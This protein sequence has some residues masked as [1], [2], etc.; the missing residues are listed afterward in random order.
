MSLIDWQDLPGPRA[1]P[2]LGHVMQIRPHRAHL[3]VEA[4]ARV[5][6]PVFKLRFGGQKVLVVTDHDVIHEALKQRPHGFRKP[7][8]LAQII[9]EA[10]IAPG[11]FAAEGE[12][13]QAQRQMVMA[14]FS[15][16]HVR[17]Y[18]PS[19]MAVAT[20]LAA[21]WR[22][23]CE[24]DEEIDLQADLMRYT[25]DV[26]SGLA[27]GK[28]SHTLAS[29]D[30]AMQAHLDVV[31]PALAR[32]MASFLPWWR[33]FKLPADRKLDRAV[34]QLMRA[35]D[36][37]IVQ[38]RQRMAT[39][40]SRRAHPPNLLEALIA[41]A[42]QADSQVDDRDVAANVLTVLLAGEGTT[43]DSLAW[44]IYLLARAPHALARAVA[45]ARQVAR[46][47]PHLGFDDVLA[48]PYIDACLQETMRLKPVSPYLLLQALHDTSLAGVA[49]PEGT[50]VWLASRYDA[51]HEA[52]FD[53]A[54]QFEPERWLEPDLQVAKR[55][56]M[57]F[58]SGPR[59]CPG[60]YL[61]LL[62][63]KLALVA[64]LHEF[65]VLS[66]ETADGAEPQ[67]WMAFNMTP[68]GLRMKLRP[69]PRT[70]FEDLR[71]TA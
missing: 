64:L 20:R 46:L 24:R 25:V 47:W 54:S 17:A 66:V 14:A 32:R 67:E 52:F 44:A 56:I 30:D 28:P 10:G 40:P 68:V 16:A 8:R 42:D 3:D 63:M 27:F 29:D 33:W 9:R 5:H 22:G 45:E 19:L 12:A 36:G 55:V 35:V 53:Q 26:I 43:A 11:L 7:Q 15:P 71:R 39:N 6:G 61:A 34:A 48:L 18:F 23:A 31:F 51:T 59:V 50:L 41:A 1:W 70:A 4:L 62:E 2:W 65:D 60:R 69:R 49:V 57:P 21:R 58:G 37:Y 13:W 38:A